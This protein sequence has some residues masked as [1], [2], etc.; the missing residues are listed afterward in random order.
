MT[1]TKLPNTPKRFLAIHSL[2]ANNSTEIASGSNC[3]NLSGMNNNFRPSYSL[4]GGSSSSKKKNPKATTP[5]PLKPIISDVF[6][7]LPNISLET[8][9]PRPGSTQKDKKPTK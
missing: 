8:L 7:A 9:P 3:A 2:V 1:N 4:C 5:K 6:A